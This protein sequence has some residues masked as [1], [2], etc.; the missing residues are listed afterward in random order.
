[1]IHRIIKMTKL[2]LL[3]MMIAIFLLLFLFLLLI[4]IILFVPAV[5]EWTSCGAHS[6][7]QLENRRIDHHLPPR[8]ISLN[9]LATTQQKIQDSWLYHFFPTLF[10]TNQTYMVITSNDF[11]RQ[12]IK[13]QSTFFCAAFDGTQCGA[14]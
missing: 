5:I 6:Q 7:F 3:M 14:I 9:F 1:M 10:D 4:I 8:S 2:F 12:P 11:I 13:I